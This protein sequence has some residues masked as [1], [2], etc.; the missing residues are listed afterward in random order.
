MVTCSETEWE[1]ERKLYT[2]EDRSHL[3]VWNKAENK[4][5]AEVLGLKTEAQVTKKNPNKSDKT[6][7]KRKM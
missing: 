4:K 7:K 1:G 2:I 5:K 3:K 6:P